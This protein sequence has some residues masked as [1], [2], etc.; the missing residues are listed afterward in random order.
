DKDLERKTIIQYFREHGLPDLAVPK[1][2]IYIEKIPTLGTGKTDYT[3]A[4]TALF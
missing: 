1:S 4:A 2:T 3:S